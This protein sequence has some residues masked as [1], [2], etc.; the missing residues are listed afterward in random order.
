M[1]PM[2]PIRAPIF[3]ASLLTQGSVWCLVARE[4]QILLGGPAV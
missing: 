2:L 4:R 3:M 1:P